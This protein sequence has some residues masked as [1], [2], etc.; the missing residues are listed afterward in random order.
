MD[1]F[2]A[3]FLHLVYFLISLIII[4]FISKKDLGIALFIG[5][6]IFGVLSGAN[7]IKSFYNI[8]FNVENFFLALS[9]SLIPILGGFMQNSRMMFNLIKNLRV[10]KRSAFMI[11]PALFGLLPLPG[12][13]LLSAPLVDEIDRETNKPNKVAIN[14]WFRHVLI[15]IYPLQT[16]MFAATEISGISLYSI[17]AILLIP[18]IIMILIGYFLLIYPISNGKHNNYLYKKDSG[19]TGENIKDNGKEDIKADVKED[20]KEENERRNL[21]VA[22]RNM[23]P[24]LIAPV[25]DIIGRYVVVPLLLNYYNLSNRQQD[26]IKAIILFIGLL[27]SISIAIKLSNIGFREI[28]PVKISQIK[29][30]SKRMKLWKFPLLLYAIFFFYEIF[31]QSNLIEIVSSFSFNL[32]GI[33]LISFFLGFVT[34][35]V[36]L[37]VT[38]I[39]PIYMNQFS[40]AIMPPIEFGL[41]YIAIFLGYVLTPI[42]PCVAYSMNYFKVEYKKVFK[43]L[44]K[45]TLLGLTLII[46]A[47][48]LL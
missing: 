19:G 3:E 34:G 43:Y 15:L 47:A 31:I 8:F 27:I 39:F 2:N 30:I 48:I 46:I 4:M 10:S 5:A 40:I 29:D 7:I 13:A 9:V 42:H 28:E 26:D 18:C 23:I 11:S 36:T 44:F 20:I 22:L 25:I 16:S 41:I 37:P 24:I 17:I 1:Y 14:V 35:R 45:P 33:L 12:G 21:L 32:I 6:L 38:I